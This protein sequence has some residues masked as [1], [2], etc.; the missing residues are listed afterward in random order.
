MKQEQKIHLLSYANKIENLLILESWK[1]TV[2]SII[3]FQ[4]KVK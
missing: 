1:F 2:L 3:K 4:I